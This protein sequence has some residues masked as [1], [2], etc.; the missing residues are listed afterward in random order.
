MLLRLSS[1]SPFR[2][3]TFR[4]AAQ[5]SSR[6]S[7]LLLS[8][9]SL[10]NTVFDFLIS[11]RLFSSQKYNTRRR[12]TTILFFSLTLDRQRDAKT[13]RLLFVQH[14]SRRAEPPFSS[15]TTHTTRTRTQFSFARITSKAGEEKPPFGIFFS[16]PLVTAELILGGKRSRP[17]IARS[18][19]T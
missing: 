7:R 11:P 9:R 19:H 12:A 14:V 3:Y 13:S 2:L 1:L 17:E 16:P 10:L 5:Q 18:Q 8:H 6:D 4:A 15:R